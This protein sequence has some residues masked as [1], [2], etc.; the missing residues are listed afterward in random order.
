[1]PPRS[2]LQELGSP[3]PLSQKTKAFLKCFSRAYPSLYVFLTASSAAPGLN[4]CGLA[5]SPRDLLRPDDPASYR[6]LLRTT[7]V[8]EDTRICAGSGALDWRRLGHDYLHPFCPP[9]SATFLA[10][11]DLPPRVATA[12]EVAVAARAA[13]ELSAAAAAA[14]AAA[15]DAASITA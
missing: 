10:D 4:G 13:A 7:L 14:A 1:M 2:L 5:L 11:E 8:C 12:V 3:L 9:C 15:E 6:A